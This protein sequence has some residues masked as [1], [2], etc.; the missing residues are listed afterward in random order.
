[1]LYFVLALISH[2]VAQ[3]PVATASR[4]ADIA[5]KVQM[6]D[7]GFSESV[8]VA[9]FNKDGRLDILSAEYWYEAPASTPPGTDRA[10]G[11]TKHK[12]RDIPFNGSYIDNFSDLPVDVDA[13]GFVD[14]VQ[15]AYFARRI[16]WLRNPGKGRGPWVETEIDAVGPTEFAFLVDLNN[17]G[18]ALEIL[19]QFTG[20]LKA[21]LTWY[22]VQNGKWVKHVVSSRSY[23]H[24][25]GAGDLNGDKRNDIITPAGWLEA[26]ADVRASGEWTFHPTDW[27]S[28]PS[29][30]GAAGAAGPAPPLRQMTRQEAIKAGFLVE[31]AAGRIDL[32]NGAKMTADGLVYAPA[33]PQATGSEPGMRR[34]TREEAVKGGY[35]VETGGGGLVLRNGARPAVEGMF[36]VP[37]AGDQPPAQ[38]AMRPAEYAFMYVI[39]INK[40]GRNDILTTM[41]H[42]TGVLWF[43]QRADGQWG[44]RLI[45]A[46]LANAHSSALAD[47]ND[48]GQLD[49]IAA[50]RYFGRGG[51]DPSEREPMG[52]Y[53][54]QFRPGPNGGVE[55][56]RHIIDYGGRAGGGLQMMV[57]DIDGDGDRDV[58]TAGKTGLFL[59]ENLTKKGP[60]RNAPR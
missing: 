5:F 22:E 2:L 31:D 47:L 9:D 30:P 34:I 27:A 48:D 20:A 38:P 15:I 56:I 36:D 24:G 25:I 21:P 23:G 52:I 43:E 58:I 16:V 18:K 59:S 19:P 54:Y 32:R 45:D 17:D 26:P 39:D 60:Q 55:W 7:P 40:D 12:I 10:A 8:A 50:K 28:P 41:A 33:G 4:P 44:Q 3:G 51:A 14:I 57:E 29:P 37:V 6:I 46:T 11:W 42:S 53:W 13:D 1:M 49:L 35:L